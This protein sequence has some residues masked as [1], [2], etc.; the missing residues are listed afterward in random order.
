MIGSRRRHDMNRD[1]CY[2]DVTLNDT[3]TVQKAYKRRCLLSREYEAEQTFVSPNSIAF[4]FAAAGSM[5]DMEMN[6]VSSSSPLPRRVALKLRLGII[7][8]RT[9]AAE[10]CRTRHAAY[11]ANKELEYTERL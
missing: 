11:V 1:W 6:S 2:T 8:K 10:L 5:V 7:C 3:E 9:S 4:T